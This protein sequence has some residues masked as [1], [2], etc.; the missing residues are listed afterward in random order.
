MLIPKTE[1]KISP[2]SSQEPRTKEATKAM[3]SDKAGFI[4][5]TGADA[6]IATDAGCLMNIGGCLR[7]RGGGIRILHLAEVLAAT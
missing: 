1:K 7:R 5:K 2:R 3:V 4:E 6:V